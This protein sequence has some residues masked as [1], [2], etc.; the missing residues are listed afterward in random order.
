MSLARL[1]LLL[2]SAAALSFAFLPSAFAALSVHAPFS[3]G[4]ILQRDRAVVIKGD[5]NPGAEVHVR[6]GD[7]EPLST[8]ADAEGR[9][10]IVAGSRPAWTR[11]DADILSGSEQLHVSNLLF[12]DVWLA[13]GQSNIAWTIDKSAHATRHKAAAGLP[14][15]RFLVI[16]NSLAD[17]PRRSISTPWI[18]ASPETVGDFSAVAYHFARRLRTELDVPVGIVQ[19]TWG[20]TWIESWIP[21]DALA[22][23]PELSK[24]FPRWQAVL[25]AHPAARARYEVAR[26]EWLAAYRANGERPPPGLARPAEP[27]GPG[28]PHQPSSVF[29]GLVHPLAGTPL[30]GVL[31]YQGESNVHRAWIYRR[32]LPAMIAAWRELWRDPDLPFVVAQLPRYGRPASFDAG[33]DWAAL[34]E[35][36]RLA[37]NATPRTALAVMIDIGEPGQ[38]HPADKLTPGIRLADTALAA[39]YGRSDIPA[40]GPR[41]LSVAADGSELVLSFSAAR[42]IL[43]TSDDDA[44]RGFVLAGADRVWRPATARLDGSTIRLSHPDIAA[45]VAARYAWA[46]F[47]DGNLTDSTALPAEPFRTDD[48]PGPTDHRR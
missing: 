23:D 42:G 11:L 27:R 35:S 43:R 34:R 16:P 6:L 39:V 5:A 18:A 28:H 47:P 45:P 2:V 13:A 19:A 31:W 24:V 32:Q 10:H 1:A 4:A 12:G 46:G 40:T 37:V 22:A 15:I 33:S 44:P 25:D 26:R 8:R 14:G 7:D 29:N 48:W 17:T 9:W 36:Q 3:D 41:L 30:R 20:G 38:I 21:R